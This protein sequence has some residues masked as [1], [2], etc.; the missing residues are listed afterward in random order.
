M[1]VPVSPRAMPHV[2]WQESK[3]PKCVPVRAIAG[4]YLNGVEGIDFL[5]RSRHRLR[6]KFDDDCDGLDFYG[7]VYMQPE[8]DRLC[9]GRDVI[10]SRMGAT[11]EIR[12]FRTLV[13]ELDE[14]R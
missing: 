6:A 4:A 11:C 13:P 3:G 7:G 14:D 1:R 8:D 5:L 12:R 10:R 2:V 9:A